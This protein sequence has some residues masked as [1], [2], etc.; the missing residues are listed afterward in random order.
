M[1]KT[2]ILSAYVFLGCQTMEN[3]ERLYETAAFDNDCPKAK[4]KVLREEYGS[5]WGK[6]DLEVCGKILTYQRADETYSI[7]EL[8]SSKE[9]QASEPTID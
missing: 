8:G 3:K 6:Y 9:M 2:F 5:D 7:E 1:W 4:I